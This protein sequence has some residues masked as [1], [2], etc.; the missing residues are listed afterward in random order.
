MNKSISMKVLG[1]V[2]ALVLAVSALTGCGE[3]KTTTVATTTS[4]QSSDSSAEPTTEMT[5][6]S[7]TTTEAMTQPQN[8]KFV[9]DYP[10]DMKELGFTEPVELEKRPERV[11][12]LTV[13]P[14]PALFELD[15]KMV[16]IPTSRVLT[17]PEEK[18][19]DIAM[20]QF[21]PHSPEDFDFES[22]IVLEPDL[23][24]LSSGA[25]D[26]AGKKLAEEFNLPV[27]Y[28][29]GGHTVKYSSVKLQTEELVKAFATGDMAA[30]G[31]E[32]M[33]RFADL[34]VKV[35]GAKEAFNGK[36]VMVVQSGSDRH[37][38]QTKGGTLGS[39]LEMLGFVN[40]FEN[41]GSSMVPLDLEQALS[42]NPDYVVC[43]G[44]GTPDDHKN[45]ME[46]VF[47][48]NPDYWHSISAI[49]DGK[50]LYLGTEY[51]ANTGLHIVEHIEKLVDYMNK[52]TGMAQ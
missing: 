48:E 31:E 46:K 4:S 9:L 32:M 17:W 26:T 42:Y 25:K 38:I 2:M 19:K 15:V 6:E 5:T 20:V 24:I 8:Q 37:F 51:V 52:L 36:T 16:G 41:E 12:C 23:V 22:L 47:A 33:K 39:M 45:M 35:E 49:K 34:E 13:A 29:M 1:V 43:V 11:V 44:S 27:Y 40:V 21:N 3:T 14:V 18:T 28:V 7:A 50:V 30:K 10:A